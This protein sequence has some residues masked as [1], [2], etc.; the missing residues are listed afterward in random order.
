LYVI[1]FV[2][3][4]EH[5]RLDFF[6]FFVMLLDGQGRLIVRGNFFAFK[7]LILLLHCSLKKGVGVT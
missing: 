4:F 7:L 2:W 3:I 5:L 1:P 6:H